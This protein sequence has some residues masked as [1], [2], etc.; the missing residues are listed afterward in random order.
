MLRFLLEKRTIA[1]FAGSAIVLYIIGWAVAGA[2]IHCTP[3]RTSS[4]VTCSTP[5]AA[6]W[7]SGIL[8]FCAWILTIL[9]WAMSLVKT[10]RVRAWVWLF[11]CFILPPIGPLF[12]GIFGPEAPA[13][14]RPTYVEGT[15]PT[16]IR[17]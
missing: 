10:Y 2:F 16:P 15:P 1:I 7:I 4:D 9:C 14:N 8:F 13:N 17:P 6:G 3:V 5:T 12:Y 11:F